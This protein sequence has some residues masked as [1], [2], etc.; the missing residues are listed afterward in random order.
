[1]SV[2]TQ[3]LS[4]KD[5]IDGTSSVFSGLSLQSGVAF[6]VKLQRAGFT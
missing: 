2:L 6:L 5:R 4:L 3:Q 1:M